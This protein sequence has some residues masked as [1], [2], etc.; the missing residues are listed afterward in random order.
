MRAITER[1][2]LRF[3]TG[4]E[5]IFLTL[6]EVDLDRFVISDDWLRHRIHLLEVWW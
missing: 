1:L 2:T 3:A 4:T 5:M 6:D